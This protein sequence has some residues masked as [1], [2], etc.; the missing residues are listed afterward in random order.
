M[1]FKRHNPAFRRFTIDRSNVEDDKYADRSGRRFV[2]TIYHGKAT[3]DAGKS[4]DHCRRFI[5][6]HGGQPAARVRLR[7]RNN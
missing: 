3:Y 1:Q 6:L 7:C 5:C 4:A 2:S